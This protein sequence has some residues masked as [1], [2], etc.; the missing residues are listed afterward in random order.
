[1]TFPFKVVVYQGTDFEYIATAISHVPGRLL[2]K[3]TK[4]QLFEVEVEMCTV[5]TKLEEHLAGE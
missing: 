3:T 5:I 2:I 1:M 4:N